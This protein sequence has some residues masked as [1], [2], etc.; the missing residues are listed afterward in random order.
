MTP[1][2]EKE[3]LIRLAP[4][5]L[6]C[7]FQLLGGRLVGHWPKP[8]IPFDALGC[9]DYAAEMHLLCQ[10]QKNTLDKE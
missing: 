7:R 4:V 8:N 6:A 3:F 1:K 9:N 2:A 5:W 10:E